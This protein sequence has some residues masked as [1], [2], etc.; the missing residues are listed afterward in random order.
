MLGR[1]LS[2]LTSG[3]RID[4]VS[5]QEA[6]RDGGTQMVQLAYPRQ[7]VW[8]GKNQLGVELPF[9]LDANR[10]QTIFKMDEWGFPEVWTVSLGLQLPEDLTE[11]QIF[12][13]VGEVNFG[14]GG[15][16]QQFDV[17]W[18]DGT[19]F[20][21]PM[22]AINVRARWNS[23]ALI[24]GVE[25]PPG[26]RV[27]TLIARSSIRHARATF[28]SF[29]GSLPVGEFLRNTF[30]VPPIFQ[31]IPA[32]AKSVVVVPTTPAD[33]ANLYAAG[34]SLQFLMNN[35]TAVPATILG[36]PGTFLGPTAS[37]KVPIPATAR[38]FTF[39]NGGAAP[40]SGELIWNLFDE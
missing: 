31:P 30:A 15:I 14:S 12:D 39:F 29:M 1:N 21:L 16:M 34:S 25:P 33:A 32:F 11:G 26:I 8:S 2:I 5:M 13:I 40:V 24:Q 38:Y 22:N 18:V 9:Q 35:N 10:M 7:G 4:E 6:R 17:D 3:D 20:S 23:R 37:F 36:V 19:A 27:S 28:T